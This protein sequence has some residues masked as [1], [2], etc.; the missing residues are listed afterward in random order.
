M[1]HHIIYSSACDQGTACPGTY[2]P[3]LVSCIADY[4]RI[5][6]VIF[7][8]SPKTTTWRSCMQTFYLQ[9]LRLNSIEHFPSVPMRLFGNF[10]SIHPI[11]N[12]AVIQKP[13]TRLVRPDAGKNLRRLSYH[14]VFILNF[15]FEGS[16]HRVR[17]LPQYIHSF[18]PSVNIFLFTGILMIR[19]GISKK[20]L[21]GMGFEENFS[22]DMGL[23]T[24]P[25][26][27]RPY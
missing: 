19:T 20:I 3:S 9:P 5:S 22:W 14:L 8:I 26:Q 16:L 4:P 21:L 12:E 25:L 24:P 6:N 23:T 11:D 10:R 15:W 18:I 2:K 27:D 13:K 7:H 1:F 17:V